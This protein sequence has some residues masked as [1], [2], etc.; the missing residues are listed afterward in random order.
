MPIHRSVGGYPITLDQ[1]DVRIE[2]DPGA[3]R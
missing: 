1:E 2:L 3:A